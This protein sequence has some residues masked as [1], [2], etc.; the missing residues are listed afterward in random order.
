MH[1]TVPSG[2]L[3]G[4]LISTVLHQAKSAIQYQTKD[5]SL[6][7]IPLRDYSEFADNPLDSVRTKGHLDRGSFIQHH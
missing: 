4:T 6:K 1:P 3:P 2:S 7:L 5:G